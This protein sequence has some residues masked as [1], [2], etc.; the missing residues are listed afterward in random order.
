MSAT[1]SF[2]DM[3]AL[4]VIQP[5]QQDVAQLRSIFHTDLEGLGGR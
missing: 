3:L 5:I 2:H 1:D 4:N